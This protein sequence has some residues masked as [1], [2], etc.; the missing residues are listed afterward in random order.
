MSLKTEN[1]K[2]RKENKALKEELVFYKK[3]IAQVKE[4]I[5]KLVSL[6]KD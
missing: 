2:L 3:T 5:K 1:T 6:R 4:D